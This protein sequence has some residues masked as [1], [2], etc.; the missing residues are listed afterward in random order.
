MNKAY[1]LAAA[2][3]ALC[4][5]SMA[6]A[7]PREEAKDRPEPYR[8]L[9]ACRELQEAQ[10]RL[11]CY[12]RQVA[13]LEQATSRHEIVIADKKAVDTAKRG[14]FGFA[15]PVAK[16]MGF[17]GSDAA[18]DELKAIET[19]VTGVRRAA[20]GWVI[21]FEDGSTWEQNDTRDFVLSPKIG[22]EAKI[23]RGLLGTFTVSVRGQ[24]PIKMRRVK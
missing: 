2:I 10:A 6:A 9:V 7:D 20:P 13:A 23:E 16:L 19:T 17:G 18:G 15:A 14:L 5:Q 22:N 8:Q 3:L 1:L 21:D 4:S 24:R 12:D 11:A